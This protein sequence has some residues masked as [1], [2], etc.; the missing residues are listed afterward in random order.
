MLKF[1]SNYSTMLQNFE[2]F[3]LVMIVQIFFAKFKFFQTVSF[4]FAA[5]L[6]LFT[7]YHIHF[8]LSRTFS[9]LFELRSRVILLGCLAD[10]FDIIAR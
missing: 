7:V 3:I 9:I 8:R 2:D 1:Q 6:R 4:V 10:S 5:L